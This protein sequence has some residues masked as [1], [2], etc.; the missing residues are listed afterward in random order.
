MKCEKCGGTVELGSSVNRDCPHCFWS[1]LK[2]RE[3]AEAR[4]KKVY[5]LAGWV[6]K[7]VDFYNRN[8][9]EDGGL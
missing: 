4:G 2:L 5:P 1:Y 6:L 7:I 9:V 3:E 8:A